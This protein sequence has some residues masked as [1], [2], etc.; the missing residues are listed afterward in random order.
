[1][2]RW[3]F[4]SNGQWY[5]RSDTRDF[6]EYALNL[7]SG[8]GFVNYWHE[9]PEWQGFVSRQM[10]MPGYPLLLAAVYSLTGFDREMYVQSLM[11]QHHPGPAPLLPAGFNPLYAGVANIVLD[12][13]TMAGL[14]M[15]GCRYFSTR[16][17]FLA[18]CLYTF[19]VMWTPQL[20]S[21]SLFISAFVMTLALLPSGEQQGAPGQWLAAGLCLGIAL[22]TKPIGIVIPAAVVLLNIR[23]L[24]RATLLRLFLFLA[25]GAVALGSLLLRSYLLYGRPFIIA[26]GALA[27]AANTL[28]FNYSSDFLALKERLGRMPNELEMYNH[29]NH[30]ARDFVL[31]N[32]GRAFLIYLRNFVDLWTLKPGWLEQWLWGAVYQEVPEVRDWHQ[33]LF[34]LNYL[35]YPLGVWGLI[36]RGRK[37]VLVSL[38]I[39]LFF[40]VHPAVSTGTFR[41]MAPVATL[42]ILFAAAALD[43]GIARLASAA[44]PGPHASAPHPNL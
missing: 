31:N 34:Y 15:L 32:P 20:V 44:P 35:T 11:G 25:P 3:Y 26:N 39:L 27:I 36:F 43:R 37:T 18:Q 8:R 7:L 4:V 24:S 30:L 5:A 9:M 28:G 38:T 12:M 17:A 29:Y 14:V 41:Y 22:L 21:E 10:H 33:T 16:T 6:H 2:L 1:M 40:L 13:F 42:F 23:R 19:Y